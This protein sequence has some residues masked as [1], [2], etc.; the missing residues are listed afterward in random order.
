[1]SV[2]DVGMSVD[3]VMSVDETTRTCAPERP[4]PTPEAEERP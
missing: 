3:V 1:M 4:G 2:D